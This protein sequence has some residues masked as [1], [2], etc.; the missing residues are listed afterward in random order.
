MKRASSFLAL[1]TA[2]AVSVTSLAAC[3]ASSDS[4]TSD[5]ESK[6]FAT[7][8]SQ[9]A[10]E[11]SEVTTTTPSGNDSEP[12]VE[13]TT[14]ADAEITPQVLAYTKFSKTIEAQS[15]VFSGGIKEA[16]KRK[17][18]S[19][20]KYLTGFNEAGKDSWSVDVEL[21]SRQYYNIVLILGSDELKV[22]SLMINGEEYG[23]LT[24]DNS[25]KFQALGFEN[26]LLEQ[27]VN[28][29]AMGI[30]DGGIDFDY[31]KITASNTVEKLNTAYGEKA[32]YLSNKKSDYHTQAVFNYLTSVYGSNI[33]SGQFA[34]IGTSAET[35]AVYE[36]TG[37][38]PAIR[39]GDLI[40]YTSE[41]TYA[42]DVEVAREW[43]KQGGLVGYIWHWADPLGKD[44]YYTEETD[45]D[46]SKAVTKEDISQLSFEELEKMNE[47]G[48]ISNECLALVR[49]IDTIS[50]QLLTIQEDGVTVLWRP[51]HEASGGWFWWGHDVKSYKWL[52]ALMYNRQTK[53]F[54]LNNLIWVWNGQNPDWYVGDKYCDM[55]SADIYD[56]TGSSQLNAFL[57]LRRINENKPLALSECGNAPDIQS[58]ADEK[59]MWSFFSIWSGAYVIDEYG[60]YSEEYNTKQQMIDLYS[61]NIV[62]CRDE[63]P[64]FNAEADKLKAAAEKAAADKK[65]AE[66]NK[67]DKT[68]GSSKT[69]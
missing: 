29:F 1:F 35:D 64:D 36:I 45:F 24:T 67:A 39:F 28:S 52:W 8:Q 47:E 38:Y 20:E 2:L 68:D 49:D 50:Q 58:F 66:E 63:L 19:K 44:A 5:K 42:N 17:G 26:V 30:V 61:N 41:T 62:V 56:E 7:G 6:S 43:A 32:P 54:G 60:K 16:K 23:K 65:A 53:Y 31:I 10:E 59:V 57:S 51:L 21:P 48:T 34:T 3:S 18:A 12:D 33:V 69:E 9:Q 13:V 11:S 22:N 25:G 40:S 46:L 55:I 14:V 15:G 37:H 4:T 27:G